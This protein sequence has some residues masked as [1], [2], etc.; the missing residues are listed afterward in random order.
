[1]EKRNSQQVY[2]TIMLI[3]ITV[4]ITALVTTI[5]IYNFVIKSGKIAIKSED[6]SRLSGLEAT[7]SSCRSVL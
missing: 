3:I 7:L 4:L 2:K 5:V 1:M 6:N